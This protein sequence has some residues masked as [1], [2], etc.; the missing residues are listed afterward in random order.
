MDNSQALVYGLAMQPLLAWMKKL[1]YGAV[2]DVDMGG[3]ILRGKKGRRESFLA[4]LFLEGTRV[5]YEEI[6]HSTVDVEV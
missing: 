4:C 5:K 3:G 1:C 6:Q 2:C